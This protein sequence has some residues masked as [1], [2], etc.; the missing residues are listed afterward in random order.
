MSRIAKRS[1]IVPKNVIIKINKQEVV[2]KGIKGRLK[3]ILHDSVQ[4]NYKNNVLS[5]KSRISSGIGWMHA[6]TS[7][8]LIN[9][10]IIGVTIGFFKQL[11]LVG[12]GY[13]FS[14]EGSKQE[15]IVMSLGYSHSV[16]YDLPIG[17]S[18]E[19]KSQTEIVIKGIDKRLVGQVAENLRNFRKPDAYKGKGIRYA[20]E[21]VRIKEA[22]KK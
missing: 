1:I 15:K 2:I 20:N 18:A 10:M 5:F 12:V 3:L 21:F 16:I 17:I 14:L 22:K 7:R 8:S 13:R 9:S 4:I 11:N 6:G 19:L